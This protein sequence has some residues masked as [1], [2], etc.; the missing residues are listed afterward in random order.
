MTRRTWGLFVPLLAVAGALIPA[1]KAT[2][3]APRRARFSEEEFVAATTKPTKGSVEGQVFARTRGG[4]VIVGAGST[5]FAFPAVPYILEEVESV[6]SKTRMEPF[7]ARCNR[8]ARSVRA[9][10]SGWFRFDG[11]AAGRWALFSSVTWEAG[12][13]QGGP[14]VAVVDV[15]ADGTARL[16]L[17]Y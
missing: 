2:P 7:D 15:P 3:P 17:A 4:A 14:V 5:V 16:M 10:G 11:L 6:R 13:L 12:S 1:C 9:D 8:Y